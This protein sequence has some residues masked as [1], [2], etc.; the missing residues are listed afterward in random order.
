MTAWTIIGKTLTITWFVT[1]M[2]ILVEYANVLSVDRLRSALCGSRV[3]QYLVAALLGAVP[4]CLGAFVVVAL[5]IHRSVTLGAVVACMIATSGDEAFV[6]LAMFPQRALW[7]ALALLVI[8]IVAGLLTDMAVRSSSPRESCGE[9]EV[10]DGAVPCR[11][12]DPHTILDD[13]RRPSAA[14]GTLAIATTLFIVGIVS[15]QVGPPDW[16]W[17]RI[18]LVSLSTLALSVVVTVP[19][20]FI[21]DHLWGHV[22]VRHVPRIFVWTLG[23]MVVVALLHIWAGSVSTLQASPWLMLA[24]AALLGLIPESGP[25]LV[26]VMLYADGTVPLSVLLASSIVQDGHGMLPLL[27]HSWRDFLGVKAIN[28]VAG[29]LAGGAMLLAGG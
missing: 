14:R 16:N 20:H 29:L 15:G 18:T 24:G 22:V 4:G 27:A 1:V 2:M 6:M 26:V 17:V 19:D 23:A 9:M 10:H 13:L 3:T 11:C 5:F 25:H 28:L 12:F 8:G 7:L 21:E